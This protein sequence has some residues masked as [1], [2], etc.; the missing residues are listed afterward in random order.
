MDDIFTF[1]TSLDWFI[2]VELQNKIFKFN[3]LFFVFFLNIR[4]KI[5]HKIQELL[6][7]YLKGSDF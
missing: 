2:V 3:F 5:Q 6:D 7:I 1:T 4:N